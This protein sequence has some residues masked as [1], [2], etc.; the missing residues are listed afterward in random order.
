MSSELV[1]VVVAIAVIVFVVRWVTSSSRETPEEQRIRTALGFRPKNVSPEMVRGFS[2]ISMNGA[3][4][5]R[6]C[7]RLFELLTF[8][9][10]C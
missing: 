3:S 9:L 8:V 5:Q 1:N 6:V 2:L 7:F 10:P 4:A